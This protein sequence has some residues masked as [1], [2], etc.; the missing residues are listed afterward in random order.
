MGAAAS[1]TAESPPEEL[2]QAVGGI[3]AAYAPYG[4][5]V[6]AEGVDGQVVYGTAPDELLDALEVTNVLHRKRLK[7]EIEK[8]RGGGI[9]SQTAHAEVHEDAG[10]HHDALIEDLVQRAKNIKEITPESLVDK[11][12]HFFLSYRQ[13]TE[14]PLVNALYLGI[15]ARVADVDF[16]VTGETVISNA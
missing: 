7:N 11:I 3:A 14:T 8:L 10:H 13:K 6:R 9:A 2:A 4:E 5:R 16:G 15:K 12:Q 1:I